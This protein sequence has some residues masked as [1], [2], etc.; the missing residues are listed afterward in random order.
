M[1]CMP[2]PRV[3]AP[4]AHD[5]HTAMSEGILGRE[6]HEGRLSR[7]AL[8]YRL[9][10]RTRE[11]KRAVEQYKPG[12]VH[13]ILD[14]GTADGL[15]LQRLSAT[16]PE[17]ECIGLDM[18]RELLETIGA[19]SVERVQANAIDLPFVSNVF[20]LLIATAV[21]EHV[22]R[23]ARLVAECYRVLAPRGL[24]VVSTPVPFFDSIATAIGHI[25]DEEHNV[26]FDL[27]GLQTLFTDAGFDV[28]EADKFM[29]S[30]WGFPAELLIE[31]IMKSIGLRFLL[32]NQLLVARKP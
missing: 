8:I 2:D 23:P 22:S 29:M 14:V 13:T 5:W 15:M 26:T 28:L 7:P 10:R 17:T 11:V 21:I 6:Y 16:W 4:S 24:L 9:A 19:P 20:D 25:P 12:P 31:P 30:P 1:M 18:S 27:E 3:G 32:L